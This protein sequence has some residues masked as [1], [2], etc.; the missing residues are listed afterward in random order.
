MGGL[1]MFIKIMEEFDTNN[2]L[3][4]F[5]NGFMTLRIM[6]LERRQKIILQFHAVFLYQLIKI[7]Q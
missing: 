5:D 4:G 1:Y 2:N 3:L 7:F 6:N